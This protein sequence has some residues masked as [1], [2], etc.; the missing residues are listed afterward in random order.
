MFRKKSALKSLKQTQSRNLEAKLLDKNFVHL[1]VSCYNLLKNDKK[2]KKL[3]TSN[4]CFQ[5]F[6]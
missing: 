3:T 4:N 1:N 5:N 6:D 2:N